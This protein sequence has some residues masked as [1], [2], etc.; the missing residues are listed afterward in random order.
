M[1]KAPQLV[2]LAFGHRQVVPEIQQHASAVLRRAI[3]P[4]TRGVFVDLDDPR[5]PTYPISFCQG[6]DGSLE[7]GTGS[8]QFK[9]GRPFAQV[10]TT[11]T[12][13]TQRL[14]LAVAGAVLDQGALRPGNAIESARSIG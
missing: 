1:D 10:D 12:G 6:A 3:Q 9:V 13:A 7:N 11:P 14:F 5:R 2:Q 8:V 4:G